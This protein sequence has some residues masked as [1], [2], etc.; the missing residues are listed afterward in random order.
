MAN[1]V[2]TDS[3]PVLP[4]GPQRQTELNVQHV[5]P[6][7]FWIRTGTVKVS[8]DTISYLPNLIFGLSLSIGLST[9]CRWHRGLHYLRI[10]FHSGRERPYK[11]RCHSANYV[12]WHGLSRWKLRRWVCLR[13]LFAALHDLYW[14]EFEQLR[15]LRIWHLQI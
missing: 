3:V 4:A 13:G 15:H 9:V 7:S 11:V 10:G 6:V 14:A 1:V 8:H 2:P 5:R 12:K